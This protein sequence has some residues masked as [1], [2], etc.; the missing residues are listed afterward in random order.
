MSA[1]FLEDPAPIPTSSAPVTP[2]PGV[3][4]PQVPAPSSDVPASQ[5]QL[6][7]AQCECCGL[8]EDCTPEYLSRVRD[9]HAGRWI[10]G[11]CAEAVEEELLRSDGAVTSTEEAVLR[12]VA[13]CSQFRAS[14]PPQPASP[15][16]AED[17]LISAVVQLLRRSLSS[18]SSRSTPS[19][20]VRRGQR[21][22]EDGGEAARRPLGR[23]GSCLPTLAG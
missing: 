23:S 11:L 4:D 17:D 15:S 8:T 10:C 1:T 18:P 7:S 22:E 5:L 16:A 19:S 3:V 2:G 13:F 20:P 6:V 12:H 9:R 14:S 21:G